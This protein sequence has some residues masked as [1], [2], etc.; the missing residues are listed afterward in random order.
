MPDEIPS[1]FIIE[2]GDSRY[3]GIGPHSYTQLAQS[4]S[5]FLNPQNN[6]FPVS[7]A[8]I[9]T[10]RTSRCEVSCVCIRGNMITAPKERHMLAQVARPGNN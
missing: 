10:H 7:N 2:F 1:E 9:Y 8:V 3:F 4:Y 5:V 6:Y